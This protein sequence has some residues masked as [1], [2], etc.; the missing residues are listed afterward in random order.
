MSVSADLKESP[1]PMTAGVRLVTH[2]NALTWPPDGTRTG[3]RP[4]LEVTTAAITD[5][6][7]AH[8]IV[9]RESL[10]GLNPLHATELAAGLAAA[11]VFESTGWV[12]VLP[13]PGQ[14]GSLTGPPALS[15]AAVEAGVAVIAL[16]AG[17]ALVPSVVGRGVQ[18]Q[19]LPAARPR[20]TATPYEAERSL[21]EAV[22]GVGQALAA[23]DVSGGDR[24][25]LRTISLPQ[26]YEARR[27][28]SL[29]KAFGLYEACR[30]ALDDDGTA[31]SSYEMFSRRQHLQRLLAPASDLICAVCS[32]PPGH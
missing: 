22:L 1:D 31:I 12:L 30:V 10:L 7:A 25:P 4:S 20:P 28:A 9:D 32:T 24:P 27:Q 18:W 19:V 17:I 23:L 5:E 21:A 2:L 15:A 6:D 16:E 8:H 14:L 29:D 26:R 11:T 3:I 13:R